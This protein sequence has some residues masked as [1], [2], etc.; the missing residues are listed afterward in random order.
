MPVERD[1]VQ[2]GRFAFVPACGAGQVD[3]CRD[4]ARVAVYGFEAQA[5]VGPDQHDPDALAARR[6]VQGGEAERLA[7]GGV[8]S[9]AVA[10]RTPWVSAWAS[11]LPG[12]H[13][14]AAVRASR[15][16]IAIAASSVTPRRPGALRRCVGGLPAV[17]SSSAWA[18]PRNPSAR[19]R[20]AIAALQGRP[21]AKPPAT[22]S[23]SLTNSGDGG[24][25]AR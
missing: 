20:V 8:D 22:I 2:V 16:G 15:Q 24:R 19:S 25:P 21:A 5:A 13:S 1:A 9:V 4:A 23:I 14:A 17:V 12:S 10:H 6:R 7:E 18:R 11:A 3:D